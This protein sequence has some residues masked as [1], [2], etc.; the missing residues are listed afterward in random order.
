MYFFLIFPSILTFHS[1][2]YSFIHSCIQLPMNLSTKHQSDMSGWRLTDTQEKQQ[3]ECKLSKAQALRQL[4][5]YFFGGGGGNQIGLENAIKAA[6][7]V[8]QKRHKIMWDR[9][10]PRL[11]RGINW[12]MHRKNVSVSRS[13]LSVEVE[14]RQSPR[15]SG[16]CWQV[17]RRPELEECALACWLKWPV[18]WWTWMDWRWILKLLSWPES[19]FSTQ[20]SGYFGFLHRLAIVL[21]WKKISS[22]SMANWGR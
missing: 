18:C 5:T 9:M 17:P 22:I 11:I 16:E 14:E 19:K 4:K 21:E 12:W 20:P 3:L 6:H 10:A 8:I 7:T 1:F 13:W 15:W 2:I